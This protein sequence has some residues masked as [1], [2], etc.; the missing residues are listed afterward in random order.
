MASISVNVWRPLSQ[1]SLRRRCRCGWSWTW[2]A[3]A[4]TS[5]VPA[6]WLWHELQQFMGKSTKIVQGKTVESCNV[7]ECLKHPRSGFWCRSYSG[8]ILIWH[9][10]LQEIK[11]STSGD[12]DIDKR[13][14]KMLFVF[15]LMCSMLPI[16]F[17]FLR[18]PILEWSAAS[19]RRTLL[20][21]YWMRASPTASLECS[22]GMEWK[23]RRHSK[24]WNCA[25]CFS[26][27]SHYIILVGVRL[28]NM[29]MFLLRVCR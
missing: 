22:T 11:A 13:Q 28:G 23:E 16:M 19:R 10:L 14:D 26:V 6:T 9:K 21:V 15:I 8:E 5:D 4:S 27:Q 25:K 24:V 18:C 12:R 1:S 3:S 17:C 7:E 20:N 29:I 2:P